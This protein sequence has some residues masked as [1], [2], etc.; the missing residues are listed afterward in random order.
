MRK[1]FLPLLLGL[2][3]TSC[4]RDGDSDGSSEETPVL[5]TKY[6]STDGFYVNYKYNGDK[7]AETV[8]VEGSNDELKKVFSYTDN[9]ITGY[10]AYDNNK[11][12]FEANLLYNNGKLVEYTKSGLAY[13]YLNDG[14]AVKS[15]SDIYKYEHRSDN[16][17][18]RTRIYT[19]EGLP[20]STT[21]DT[22]K[23]VNGVLLE[24][25]DGNYTTTYQYDNKNNPYKNVKGLENI[26]ALVNDI[27]EVYWGKG[28]V[29][30]LI[31]PYVTYT[32]NSL[33]YPTAAIWSNG[34]T[35]IK[36]TFTYNK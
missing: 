31:D 18:I 29:N 28:K 25:T 35:S 17:I 1:L 2:T 3:L 5:V 10:V 6:E 7:L 14:Y 36:Y 13:V 24:E 23:V 22:L 30:N 16:F 33:D 26:I 19:Q 9:L 20:Q 32:Y 8:W 4:S 34:D 15:F 12:M 21:V 11:K 27:D